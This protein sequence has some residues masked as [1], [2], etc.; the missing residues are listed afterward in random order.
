MGLAFPDSIRVGSEEIICV[1]SMST[2]SIHAHGIDMHPTNVS[3]KSN[4]KKRWK[5]SLCSNEPETIGHIV[6]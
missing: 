3:N 2:R 1:S 5:S 6:N 4:I